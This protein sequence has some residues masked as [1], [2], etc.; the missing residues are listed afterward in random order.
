MKYI[1]SLLLLGAVNGQELS[2][3]E[4]ECGKNSLF[5]KSNRKYVIKEGSNEFVWAFRR[6]TICSTS[7]VHMTMREVDSDLYCE[8]DRLYN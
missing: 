1:A 5:N 2:C 3:Y 6:K 8:D 7:F 4:R